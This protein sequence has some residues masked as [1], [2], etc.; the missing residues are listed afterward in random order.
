MFGATV[1]VAY[2]ANKYGTSSDEDKRNMLEEKFKSDN[3]FRDQ[4]KRDM[5][6][7]FDKM[8]AADKEQESKMEEVLK[9]GVGDMKRLH[10]LQPQTS[11]TVNKDVS[12]SNS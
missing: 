8:K 1:A 5:Q 12:Q 9:K 3:K 7:F 2:A 10:E 11:N 4:K 6:A